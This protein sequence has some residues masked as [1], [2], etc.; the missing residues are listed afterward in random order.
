MVKRFLVIFTINIFDEI[1][2]EITAPRTEKTEILYQFQQFQV[3]EKN[4]FSLDSG[5]VPGYNPHINAKTGRNGRLS[6]LR[7]SAVGASR[8]G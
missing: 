5:L 4:T 3:H 2:T 1:K 7:E 6:A 8:R